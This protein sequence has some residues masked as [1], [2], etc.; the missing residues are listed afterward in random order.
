V[1]SVKESQLTLALATTGGNLRLIKAIQVAENVKSMASRCSSVYE[2]L[3]AFLPSVQHTVLDG[4]DGIDNKADNFEVEVMLKFVHLFCLMALYAIPPI[5]TDLLRQFTGVNRRLARI[6]CG[7]PKEL[8]QGHGP[9]QN[10]YY[11]LLQTKWEG[12]GSE[13][14]PVPVGL[15]F[16][17]YIHANLFAKFGDLPDSAFASEEWD[18]DPLHASWLNLDSGLV[19]AAVYYFSYLGVNDNGNLT[20]EK[21]LT[22]FVDTLSSTIGQLN[23]ELEKVQAMRTKMISSFSTGFL[24]ALTVFMHWL[25]RLA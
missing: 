14:Q 11:P 24:S 7:D 10:D 9:P 12:R 13:G 4:L 18:A 22:E 25:G 6:I 16:K 15:T 8:L 23:T 17:D 20:Q 21:L 3:S 1:G 19:F 5:G 2:L